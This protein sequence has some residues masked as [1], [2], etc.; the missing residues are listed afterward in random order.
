MVS[1]MSAIALGLVLAAA[2]SGSDPSFGAVSTSALPGGSIAAYGTAGYPE[3]RAGF[4]QG[5]DAF[6]VA[7][8]AGF[9]YLRARV[10]GVGIL[11]AR[12]WGNGPLRLSADLQV[13]AFGNGGATLLDDRNTSGAGLRLGAGAT[14]A[15]QTSWPV[16][17]LATARAPLEVP[18][19]TNG[20]TRLAVLFGGAAELAVAE[21]SFVLLGTAFGP[22]LRKPQGEK[23][24]T[25]LAVEFA[26]G[27]GYRI[28]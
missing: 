15:I 7:G 13:G 11:R 1:S 28:F 19:T 22:D 3:V 8:E 23:A 20:S 2:P 14:L 25:K 21:N 10:E 16:T 27:F 26:V 24:Y 6:E 4:R 5:F 9:D 17:F 12:I 18:L